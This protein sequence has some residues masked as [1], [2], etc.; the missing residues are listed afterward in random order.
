MWRGWNDKKAGMEHLRNHIL[1]IID[2]LDDKDVQGHIWWNKFLELVE[3]YI[4]N[5]ATNRVKVN[6]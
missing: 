2:G 6:N 4:K 1:L 3:K 5:P